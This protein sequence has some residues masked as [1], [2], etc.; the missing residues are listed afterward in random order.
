M[1]FSETLDEIRKKLPL[2]ESVSDRNAFLKFIV[3]S[4]AD[5]PGADAAALYLYDNE[6]GDLAFSSGADSEG[7][8]DSSNCPVTDEN[9]Y[10]VRFSLDGNDIGRA[11]TD[12]RVI[13]HI[14]NEDESG[15][16]PS[17][18]IIV[19]I[20]R[21]PLRT[22]V[23]ILA[24]SRSDAFDSLKN[25]EILAA[26]TSL[27]DLLDDASPLIRHN[28]TGGTADTV[29]HGRKAG[30][31][32]AIG[33]ALPFWS[34]SVSPVPDKT[35]GS[36]EEELADFKSSLE[37]ALSQL[38]KI[39]LRAESEVSE[40]GAMIFMAQILMLRD[41]SFIGTMRERIE[42]GESAVDAVQAVVDDYAARFSAMNEQRLAEK[43]QDVRDLGYRLI[44]GLTDRSDEAFSYAGRIALAGHIYPSDLFRLSL[45]GASGVVL[46]GAGITAH[47]SILARSLGMPVL[48]TDDK[49]LHAVRE[50]TLLVLDADGGRLYVAPGEE[51]LTAFRERLHNAE[52]KLSSYT[53][54]GRTSDGVMVSVAANV[55]ILKDAEN[56]RI[57]GAEGI[58]LYRSEFPFI[59]R[60]DILSEEQQYQI[61][62][63][64]AETQGD[65]PVIFR[66]A[67]IGGDKILQGREEQEDNPFLGV[68]GIRFSL[69]HR[70]MFRD[71]LRA[72]SGPVRVV[73]WESCSRWC[74][75]WRRFLKPGRKSNIAKMISGS[76]TFRSMKIP[77]SVPWWNCLPP[78][79]QPRNSPGKPISFRSEPTI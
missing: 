78:R 62:R 58:G 67:D 24:G 6:Q 36:P 43:A 1:P 41:E 17:S 11:F 26:A 42:A 54:R 64:I 65:K 49:R 57:Q 72:C 75:G 61:Y 59:L 27:G 48:I 44:T 63:S 28:R 37:T 51:K 47:I 77:E 50:G 13:H 18:K 25:G 52:N 16:P 15:K 35:A 29:F 74:P 70:S 45:E 38:E 23:L 68:R 4:L 2:F 21:G 22:G 39:R 33:T 56:A 55:N 5:S 53:L 31:G 34:G 73:I 46:L 30:D 76:G 20:A 14:V 71:Q 32:L 69:A 8:W 12:G 19:P 66:T 7:L 60:N 79:W 3:K 40:T 10:P 9:G